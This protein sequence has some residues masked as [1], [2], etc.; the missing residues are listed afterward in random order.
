MNEFRVGLLTIATLIAVAVMSVK[1]TSNQSGFGKHIP[2]KT[3]L[4]DA[5]GI[6][7][8]TPIKVAGIN[9]GRI[10]SISLNGNRA[11]IDLEILDDVVVT[12]GSHMQIKTVGVLG[13]KY[14]ELNVN[15]TSDKRLAA[16]SFLET[17]MGKGLAD[18]AEEVGIVVQDV[19]EIVKE[20]KVSLM[21]PGAKESKIKQIID[22]ATSFSKDAKEL[23]ET[24]RNIAVDNEKKLIA[25]IDNIEKF[26]EQLKNHMDA[27]REDSLMGDI[28][29][30][31][32]NAEKI[33]SDLEAIVADVRNGKGTMGQ[34]LSEDEIADEVKETLAGVKKIVDKVNTIKTEVQVYSGANTDN[35]WATDAEI[36]IY[37]SP[38]RF[39]ILGLSSSEEG[40]PEEKTTTTDTNGVVSVTNE[41]EVKKN[42]YRFSAQM[43]RKLHNWYF[44]GGIIESTAG[45]GLEYDIPKMGLK[46]GSDVFDFNFDRGAN[47]RL[48]A[49]LHLWNIM[50]ARAMS[51]RTTQS[52]RSMTFSL[53]FRLLDEDLKGIMGLFL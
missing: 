30:V 28:K 27:G 33:T 47:L 18:L 4:E 24:L 38:E 45:L 44:H 48:K 51:V 14:I 26:T 41:K 11:I 1:V 8:K 23:A 42:T 15:P 9:S 43:G 21:P 6:F 13:D 40:V 12:E 34:L 3:V 52:D 49:E 20:F 25:I 37:P 46:L 39:F 10:T 29:H 5:V 36:W 17:K 22:N 53:G 35:G 16:G 31:V 19:K 2:Y 7:P 32:A 50:Y